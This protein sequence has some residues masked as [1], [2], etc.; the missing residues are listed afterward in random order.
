MSELT[1]EQVGALAAALGLPVTA[2]DLVEVTHRLN[3]LIDAL[4]PL[5]ALP[6]ETIEPVTGQ[7]PVS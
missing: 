3:G 7:G 1:T 2:E 6:L 5:A 4:E